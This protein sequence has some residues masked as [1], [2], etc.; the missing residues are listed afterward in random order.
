[1]SDALYWVEGVGDIDIVPMG[2]YLEDTDKQS[3][4][5]LM[6]PETKFYTGETAY[7]GLSDNPIAFDIETPDFRH[8]DLL[9][10]IAPPMNAPIDGIGIVDTPTSVKRSYKYIKNL[11]T[12]SDLKDPNS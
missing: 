5:D 6:D 4:S 3:E 11:L 8:I 12:P 7:K 1:M 2:D 9:N 10:A